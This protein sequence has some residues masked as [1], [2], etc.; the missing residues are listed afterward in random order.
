M[1]VVSN[2]IFIGLPVNLA[3]FGEKS[4]PFALLYY[5]ANTSFFWTI[6]V[7]LISKDG[8]SKG[9]KIKILSLKSLKSIL[10][11]PLLGFIV[12]IILVLLNIKLPQFIMDTCKYLGNLTTPL[13]LL[14]IGITFKSINLKDV[15]FDTSML[16]ILVG[17][18]ILSPLAVFLLSFFIHI[19]SLMLKVFIIQASM[20]IMAQ[21]SIISKEYNADYKYATVMVTISTVISLI[22]IPIYM[23]LLSKI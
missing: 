23:V 14:F 7:Y 11:P 9:N 10:S 13:S 19:P 22:V 21:T 16:V 20:P 17:R 4:L 6:G 8:K 12:G 3:L 18:F 5:I 2:T 15:K 1:F